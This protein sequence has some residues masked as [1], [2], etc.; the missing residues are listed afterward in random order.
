MYIE[1][2]NDSIYTSVDNGVSMRKA[3]VGLSTPIAYNQNVICRNGHPNP[4]IDAPI[5]LF[6]LY[7]EI[8]FL[9][10]SLCPHN[11]QK[12]PY[13]Y[14]LDEEYDESEVQ[15]LDL[16]SIMIMADKI[17]PT[18]LEQGV[19]WSPYSTIPNELSTQANSAYKNAISLN[20]NGSWSLS[21]GGNN[22]SVYENVFFPEPAPDE[23]NKYYDDK[24]SEHFGFDLITNSLTSY[25][26]VV[27]LLGGSKL[28]LTEKIITNSIPNFQ[29]EEGP[30]HP[31]VEDMRSDPYLNSF[32]EKVSTITE[33]SSPTDID[34]LCKDLD[35]QLNLYHDELVLKNLSKSQ[36]FKGA[37]AA[38]VGQVPIVGN[39]VSLLDGGVKMR[40]SVRNRRNYGWAGFI[41]SIRR[42]SENTDSG[43][44]I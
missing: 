33:I 37:L 1:S 9:S 34:G 15:K 38:I 2:A 18:H 32:R 16:D 14:F 7:D 31:M 22:T 29:F 19:L 27:K 35:R 25:M 17:M 41:S 30:Y 44:S 39:V 43:G 20:T 10:R 28:N 40:D 4:I 3:Y 42:I 21:V 36:V 26:G 6:L 11:M 8:W 24:I 23:F 12:L 5:G 13:V